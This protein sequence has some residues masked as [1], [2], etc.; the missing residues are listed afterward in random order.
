MT[1]DV[2]DETRE[3]AERFAAGVC[4]ESWFEAGRALAGAATYA[5]RGRRI[6]GR[7]EIIGLFRENSDW[8]REMFDDVSFDYEIVDVDG[9]LARIRFVDHLEHDGR[10]LEHVSEELAEV[11]AKRELIMNLTHVDLPGEDERLRT[12]LGEVGVAEH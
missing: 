7:R 5:L 11:S 9:A 1:D 8:A 2:A 6:L 10:I 3:V 12:F 4:E